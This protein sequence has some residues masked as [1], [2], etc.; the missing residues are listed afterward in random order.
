MDASRTR[1]HDGTGLGLAIASSLVELMDGRISVRSKPNRGSIFTFTIM[2]GQDEEGAAPTVPR[3][4]M[5]AGKQVLIVEPNDIG[6]QIL[7]EMLTEMG[8]QTCLCR[9]A[10]E[11][12]AAHKTCGPYSAYILDKSVAGAL[13]GLTPRLL[14]MGMNE[15]DIR[16]TEGEANAA[17]LYKPVY[18]D[19]LAR[20]VVGVVG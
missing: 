18:R 2:A 11:A 15:T 14:L 6:G 17:D 19:A 1:N 7:R 5:V 20:A 16:G 10:A 13:D 4:P 12:L 3:F 9:T 8:C